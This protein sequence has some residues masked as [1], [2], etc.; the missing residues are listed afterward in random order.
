MQTEFDVRTF[1]RNYLNKLYE[2]MLTEIYADETDFRVDE[3]RFNSYFD[4][5]IAPVLLRN[6]GLTTTDG[7][8]IF[9]NGFYYYNYANV[10]KD[11]LDA[12]NFEDRIRE[13]YGIPG[14]YLI[15]ESHPNQISYVTSRNGNTHIENSFYKAVC[16]IFGKDRGLE[17]ELKQET[18]SQLDIGYE[19]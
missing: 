4:D 9:H 19:R 18:P 12:I 14:N 7:A 15:E 11:Y 1:T 2:L 3:A 6:G 5:H 8:G 10:S 13:F 16:D 17:F